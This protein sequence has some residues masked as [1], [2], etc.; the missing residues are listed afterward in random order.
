MRQD[1]LTA[2]KSLAGIRFSRDTRSSGHCGEA[3]PPKYQLLPS[4]R[5]KRAGAGGGLL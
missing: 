5:D 2:T 4:V 3:L 1:V